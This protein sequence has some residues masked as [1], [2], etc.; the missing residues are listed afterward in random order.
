[1]HHCLPRCNIEPEEV[2]PACICCTSVARLPR[3]CRKTMRYFP[4]SM[5]IYP[6]QY[7]LAIPLTLTSATHGSVSADALRSPQTPQESSLSIQP[8]AWTH[9]HSLPPG[10]RGKTALAVQHASP[11][12]H[13][14]S[15]P[16]ASK[17]IQTRRNAIEKQPTGSRTS[18]AVSHITAGGRRG[19]P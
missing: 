7:S 13:S 17:W 11:S 15:M 18:Q 16:V 1:M 8:E 10:P 19:T 9:H 5:T 3:S 12:E 4:A 14:R 6:C 2:S